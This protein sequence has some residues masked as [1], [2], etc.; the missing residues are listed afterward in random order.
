[1]Y[2]VHRVIHVDGDNV[3]MAGDANLYKVETCLRN[4]IC[5]LAVSLVRKGR[6][7]SLINFKSRVAARLWRWLL[8]LRRIMWRL[9]CFFKN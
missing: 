1:Q 7:H 2:V 6:E 8:P 9:R 4:D 3:Q 5:A